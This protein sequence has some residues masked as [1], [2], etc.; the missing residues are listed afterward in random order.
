MLSIIIP[1][2][3]SGSNLSETLSPITS[4]R[5]KIDLVISDGGSIDNTPEVA[6]SY[7][8]RLINSPKGRGIQLQ[9]G[10]N[11]A[12]GDWFLFLHDDTKLSLGWDI[13]AKRFIQNPN[14]LFKAGYFI[15][16][17]KD[18]SLEAKRLEKIVNWRC[19]LLS[20]PYG[21]QGLLISRRFYYLLGGYSKIPLMEDVEFISKI[22]TSRLKQLSAL[23]ITS[24]KRYKKN[25]YFNRCFKNLICLSLYFLGVPPE[26]LIKLYNS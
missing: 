13:V 14:N 7:N 11:A 6:A 17:L 4:F 5:G 24:S 19:K 22:R 23:S 12:R 15:F 20:L 1:T 9:C 25:G 2:F 26:H 18:R 3:N 10:A 16:S 21:D 8:T